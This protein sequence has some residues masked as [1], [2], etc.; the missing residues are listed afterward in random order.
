MLESPKKRFLKSPSSKVVADILQD[1]HVMI[2][3]DYAL[4]QMIWESKVGQD[5]ETAAAIHYQITGGH[6]L[7]DLFLTL[8]TPDQPPTK[9]RSD[10]LPHEI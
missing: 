2:A 10:N 7:R 5:K 4:L 1:P 6:K 9:L 8:A 3:L